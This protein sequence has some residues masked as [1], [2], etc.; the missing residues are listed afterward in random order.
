MVV[1]TGGIDYSPL[2]DFLASKKVKNVLYTG[3]AGKRICGELLKRDIDFNV[4]FFKDLNE[5]FEI[6]ALNAVEG[7]VCL[8]SPAAASYDQYK[9]FEERGRMFKEKAVKFM[10]KR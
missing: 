7:D 10:R 9:N 1:L 8:L 2:I 5:A 3:E 6:I 4:L